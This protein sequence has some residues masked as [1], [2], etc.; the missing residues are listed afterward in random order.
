MLFLYVLFFTVIAFYFIRIVF[1]KDSFLVFLLIIL[2][3]VSYWFYHN[4]IHFPYKIEVCGMT[5]L[6][7]SIGCL[8]ARV[9]K[10]YNLIKNYIHRYKEAM[11]F[12]LLLI[13]DVALANVVK[14]P[15]N[16]RINRLG[17]YLP[18]LLLII[19]G[20]LLVLQMAFVVEKVVIVKRFFKY[21][22]EYS[23]VLIGFSLIVLQL[24]K[25]F[26]AVIHFCDPISICCKYFL[27]WSVLFLLIRMVSVHCPFLIGRK[28]QVTITR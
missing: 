16:I 13:L 7:Y 8:L 9:N 25:V 21:I 27:L 1:R 17:I 18:S 20:S 26:F 3:F 14:P 5:L 10:K 24:L 28:K 22:W 2:S 11:F 15:L 6:Y 12:S 23:I 4:S 19:S